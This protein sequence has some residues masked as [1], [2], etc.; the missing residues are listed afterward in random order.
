MMRRPQRQRDRKLEPLSVRLDPEVRKAIEAL[1]RQD[2]RS[3]SAYINRVLRDHAVG[4]G[5]LNRSV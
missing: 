3:L 2:E 1:A 5:A 4:K